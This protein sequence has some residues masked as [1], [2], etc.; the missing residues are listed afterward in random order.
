MLPAIAAERSSY[1]SV[2][3]MNRWKMCFAVMGLEVSGRWL[4]EEP[5]TAHNENGCAKRFLGALQFLYGY[6]TD[7]RNE[8]AFRKQ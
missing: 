1:L 8:S 4:V 6:L 3:S 2:Q 5:G 7:Q